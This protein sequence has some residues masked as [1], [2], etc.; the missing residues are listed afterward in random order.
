MGRPRA[1]LGINSSD[2]SIPEGFPLGSAAEQTKMAAVIAEADAHLK[3][4]S[5]RP[6]DRE[7]Y[8]TSA[9]RWRPWWRRRATGVTGQASRTRTSSWRSP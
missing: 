3:S 2:V 5:K 6:W 7:I 4:R 9:G 1:L 8:E